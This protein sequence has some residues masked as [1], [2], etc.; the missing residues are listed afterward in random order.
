MSVRTLN[1]SSGINQG[2][3]VVRYGYNHKTF[4]WPG[5][6]TAMSADGLYAE[7][8]RMNPMYGGFSV[9][10][11]DINIS[12]ALLF[13]ASGSKGALS[14][15]VVANRGSSGIVFGF[16]SLVPNVNSGI[17]LVSGE[18]YRYTDDQI[19]AVW[20]IAPTGSAKVSMYGNFDYNPNTI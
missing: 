20:A 18:S 6:N 5:L 13:S 19:F 15:V 10:G 16:N 11:T 1:A 3:T 14:E 7:N 9:T 12:G 8:S 4:N 17:L 2:N